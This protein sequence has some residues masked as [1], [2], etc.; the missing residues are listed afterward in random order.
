M[1][2]D[3]FVHL[4]VYNVLGRKVTDLVNREVKAGSYEVTF[5]AKDLSSG[6]YYYRLE[7]NGYTKTRKMILLR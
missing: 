7:T 2:G 6:V 1:P 3:G 5:D 4:A